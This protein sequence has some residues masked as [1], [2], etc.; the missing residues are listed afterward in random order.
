MDRALP[1]GNRRVPTGII[2]GSKTLKDYEPV[3]LCRDLII[4]NE[5]VTTDGIETDRLHKFEGAIIAVL[6]IPTTP[7]QRCQIPSEPHA[8]A[9]RVADCYRSGNKVISLIRR[10]ARAANRYTF[11][12]TR[13]HHSL[14]RLGCIVPQRFAS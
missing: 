6:T 11:S 12:A 10:G 4:K 8:T 2:S 14:K 13:P 9:K 1:A 7:R 5:L 3:T